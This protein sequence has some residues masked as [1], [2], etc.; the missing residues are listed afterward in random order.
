MNGQLETGMVRRLNKHYQNGGHY[1]GLNLRKSTDTIMKQMFTDV[2]ETVTYTAYIQLVPDDRHKIKSNTKFIYTV[3]WFQDENQ[4]A[5]GEWLPEWFYMTVEFKDM[6]QGNITM[7]RIV[8]RGEFNPMK[9]GKYTQQFVFTD[10]TYGEE[11]IGL[12]KYKEYKAIGEYLP[13]PELCTVSFSCISTPKS[14][15]AGN[16]NTATCRITEKVI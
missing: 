15:Y 14:E 1:Y 13:M 9:D 10:L 3:E 6:Q 4:K 5:A 16:Q 2:K 12:D 8:G 11:T 7:T